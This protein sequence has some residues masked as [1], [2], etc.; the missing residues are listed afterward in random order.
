MNILV[1]YKFFGQVRNFR[2]LLKNLY[3][4]KKF[5]LYQKIHTLPKNSY[6][7]EIFIL[8]QKFR[9]LPENSYTRWTDALS[10]IYINIEILPK[11]ANL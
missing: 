3:V 9:T 4:T 6:F 10:F 8:Y 5:I 7:T 11:E 1:K 2:S